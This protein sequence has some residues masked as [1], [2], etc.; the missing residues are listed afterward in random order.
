[1][2]FDSTLK[3][4]SDQAVTSTASSSN[5]VDLGVSG[6]NVGIGESVPLR[7]EVTENFATLTSLQ[8]SVQTSDVEGSGYVDVVLTPAIAAADLVKG[9]TFN[10]DSVPR[11]VLGRY[12]RLNYTVSGSAATAGKINAGITAGNHDNG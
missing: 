12:M 10:I 11:G 9:Y 1:M 4:S 2:I 5:V 7:I 3:F 6:R 8:V